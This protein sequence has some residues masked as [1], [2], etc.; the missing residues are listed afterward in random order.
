MPQNAGMIQSSWNKNGFSASI[1]QD[2]LGY[3]V[4]YTPETME[5]LQALMKP[6]GTVVTDVN[7][8]VNVLGLNTTVTPEDGQLSGD[9]NGV[10]PNFRMPQIWKSM[11]GIDWR[12]PVSFPLTFTVEGMFNKTLNT[13]KNSPKTLQTVRCTWDELRLV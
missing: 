9:I 4:N 13:H 8:M 6:N 11:L 2:S 3:H 10:D 1:A 5:H 7:E 12:V